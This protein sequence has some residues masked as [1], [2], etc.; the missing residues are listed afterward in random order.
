M[1]NLKDIK[2][3]IRSVRGT[4]QITRAMKLVAAAKLRRNQDRLV[5]L[6]PFSDGIA[7]LLARFLPQAVGD[8]HPLLMPREQ[9][10][11]KLMVVITGDKGL[12]GAFN[13]NILR[14]AERLCS[15][16]TDCPV[17]VVTVGR[18]GHRYL[19]RR[20]VTVREHWEDIYERLSFLTARNISKVLEEPFLKGEVDEVMVVYSHFVSP[21]EQ[22]VSSYT[23]LPLEL[24][25]IRKSAALG[26]RAARD[27]DIPAADQ[28][29]VYLFEPDVVSLCNDL[30]SRY[31][32][33]ELYRTILE[34]V[35]SEFGARM[36]A[37]DAAT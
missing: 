1:A 21:I 29:D 11:K 2:R 10:A 16:S 34:N 27:I 30:L 17:E 5:L 31:L 14:H 32:A 22:R 19:S 6:R 25:N 36:T 13:Q 23:L 12:C 28:R 7:T 9:V 3:R 4:Q 37:M 26:A 35:A 24:E 15:A 20:D 8:E 33:G 18:T